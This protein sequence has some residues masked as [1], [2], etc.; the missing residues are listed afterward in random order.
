MIQLASLNG[1]DNHLIQKALFDF[2]LIQ[3]AI[4]N[5]FEFHLIEK[6]LFECV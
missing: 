2:H 3:I 1:F 6:A 5:A 4:L